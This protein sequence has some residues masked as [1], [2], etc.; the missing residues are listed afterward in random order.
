MK[1]RDS[2]W[3]PLVLLAA[4]D[5][6][7]TDLIY[8]MHVG[9]GEVIQLAAFAAI[10]VIGQTL[11]KRTTIARF[12]AA[13]LAAPLAFYLISNFGVWIGFQSYPPTWSG[14][15]ACYVAALPF[16]GRVA[17]STAL[18]AGIFFGAHQLYTVRIAR[19]RRIHAI[20]G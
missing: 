15:A 8:R 16:Q 3:F 14:L 6:V 9:W 11:R 10:A 2:V 12:S 4:S 13:C 5:F 17:A 7:L 19:N 20:T 1:K 18:F